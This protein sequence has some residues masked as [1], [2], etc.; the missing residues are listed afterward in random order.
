MLRRGVSIFS[1][2]TGTSSSTADDDDGPRNVN[3]AI[4]MVKSLTQLYGCVCVCVCK[5]QLSAICAGQ[6]NNSIKSTFAN[7]RPKSQSKSETETEKEIETES[8][9]GNRACPL[10]LPLATCHLPPLASACFLLVATA[11]ELRQRIIEIN[12]AKNNFK[13][14]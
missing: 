3:A 9:L 11:V 4:P 6:K 14:K 8:T 7:V 1:H 10:H 13:W 5:V 2:L 12:L